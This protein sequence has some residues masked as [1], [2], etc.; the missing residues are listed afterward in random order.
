[1]WPRKIPRDVRNDRSRRAE[2]KVFDKLEKVLDDSYS[3]FYSRPWTGID[4]KGTERDGECDF[5]VA[6][7]V[8][9]YLAI[10][11]K[12]G[13]ISVDPESDQWISIDHMG[14]HNEIK[15]PLKQC[16]KSKYVILEKLKEFNVLKNKYI[17]AK[18]GVIFPDSK[19]PD[20]YLGIAYPIELFCFLDEFTDELKNWIQNRMSG[21]ETDELGI[22]GIE[23]LTEILAKKFY[24]HE[25]LGH[26]LGEVEELISTLTIDQYHI[27]EEIEEID[28]VAISGGAGT[29]KT[30]LAIEEGIRLASQGKS[31][32]IT[33]LS[34]PLAN[35]I[36]QKV[37]KYPNITVLQFHKLCDKYVKNANLEIPGNI[38]IHELF[39]VTYPNLMSKSLEKTKGPY[40]GA[41]IVDEGQDFLPNW[42]VVL[43]KLLDENK[44]FNKVRIFYDSN[45]RIFGKNLKL[46]SDFKTVP[47]RLVQNLRNTKNIFRYVNQFYEGFEIR[48]IGPEGPR[49]EF[50]E[51]NSL[52]DMR[53]GIKEKIL[54]YTSKERIAPED[55][56][57]LVPDE[58]YL[59]DLIPDDSIAGKVCVKSHMRQRDAI[60]IDTIRK[61]KGL[62]SPVVFLLVNPEVVEKNEIIYVGLSRAMTHLVICGDSNSLEYL[63]NK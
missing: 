58:I 49:V 10:E 61:F 12:G 2:C 4:R 30:I 55:I 42:W 38:S 51:K 34:V 48:S 37:T 8:Y 26:K 52:F 63:K 32:L 50:F 24:L 45:Q 6:H 29:G 40:F 31:V 5:V 17:N 27:L 41:I 28:R 16:K 18:C 43:E 46:P 56:A 47:I 36:N 7:P 21:G 9:G 62:E 39:R 44:E 3:V 14:F 54:V 15:D 53:Q 22:E 59:K 35:Y 1:M 19:R 25:P 20:E 11:V 23:I 60:V 57:I 13:G 33:C